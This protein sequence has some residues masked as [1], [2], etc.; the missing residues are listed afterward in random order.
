[1]KPLKDN[2]TEPGYK[3]TITDL[4][5]TAL[6][7]VVAAV[8][9]LYLFKTVGDSSSRIAVVEQ[10]GKIIQ[11]ID[12]DSLKEKTEVDLSGEYA[13]IILAENG[14]VCIGSSTCRDQVC[15]KTGWLTKI[16]QSSVCLPNRVVVRI[17]GTNEEF[18][19]IS[20]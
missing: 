7:L 5:V 4:L 8:L 19:A 6:I 9:S 3:L 18:D 13:T 15:V 2:W 11:E 17:I 14:K 10:N 1:M 12:L 20:K 16:G